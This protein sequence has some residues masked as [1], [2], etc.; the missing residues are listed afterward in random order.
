MD[1]ARAKRRR[2]MILTA[3]GFLGGLLVGGAVAD[4]PAA[5]GSTTDIGVPR[6]SWFRLLPMRA[7]WRV[8]SRS[9]SAAAAVPS[10]W[11]RSP[12]WFSLQPLR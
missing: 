3:G 7:T 9:A 2:G 6:A 5:A 1:A 8:G 4:G 11:F 10:F 12:C